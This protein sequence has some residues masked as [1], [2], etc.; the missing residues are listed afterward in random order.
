MSASR[1]EPNT[2]AVLYL[3]FKRNLILDLCLRCDL[4]IRIYI[5]SSID[6]KQWQDLPVKTNVVKYL[7]FD[8]FQVNTQS[9]YLTDA[10][11]S[12]L[13]FIISV[14]WH[15]DPENRYYLVYFGNRFIV[16]Q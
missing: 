5:D 1:F 9:C 12:K 8:H 13:H 15:T 14:Q 2:T 7:E 11:P 10:T 6:W 4:I 3:N 16:K